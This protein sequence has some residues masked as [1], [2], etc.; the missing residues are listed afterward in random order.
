MLSIL[1][2]I[3]LATKTG[4]ELDLNVSLSH[5]L[6]IESWPFHVQGTGPCLCSIIS[7]GPICT[8]FQLDSRMPV[9]LLSS[10]DFAYPYLVSN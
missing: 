10:L 5:R 6:T 1:L 7:E 9:G 4:L 2:L 8:S 3:P